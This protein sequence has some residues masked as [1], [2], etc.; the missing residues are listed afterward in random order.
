MNIGIGVLCKQIGVG[1]QWIVNLNRGDRAFTREGTIVPGGIAKG[2]SV[3]AAA[4]VRQAA[5]LSYTAAAVPVV[6]GKLLSQRIVTKG[7]L[8]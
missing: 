4:L 8:P 6:R 5:E 7:N 2:A 3:Q 1:L